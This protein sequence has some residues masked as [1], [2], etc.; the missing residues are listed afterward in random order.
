MDYIKS[1]IE[2]SI[3]LD[4]NNLTTQK[5]IIEE[6]IKLKK[7]ELKETIKEIK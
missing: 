7:Q 4:I 3:I 2:S 5:L 1:H 6:K